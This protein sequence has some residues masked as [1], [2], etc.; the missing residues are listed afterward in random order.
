MRSDDW[1]REREWERW[2]RRR[3]RARKRVVETSRMGI[4]AVSWRGEASCEVR[5]LGGTGRVGE[6][7]SSVKSTRRGRAA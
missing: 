4:M 3:E 5:A 1:A 2:V 7:G 6:D